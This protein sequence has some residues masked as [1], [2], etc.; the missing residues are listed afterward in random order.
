[1]AGKRF[2][3]QA[4]SAED[5]NYF[6]KGSL[7]LAVPS[8]H[9]WKSFSGQFL[10]KGC[11]DDLIFSKPGGKIMDSWKS[12]TLEKPKRTKPFGVTKT[13]FIIIIMNI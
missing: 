5:A 3:L 6:L 12:G 8:R 2:C 7:G 11:L 9:C 10:I 13:W 1:M 4:S